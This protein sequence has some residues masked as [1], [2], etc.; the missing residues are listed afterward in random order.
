VERSE[1]FD[2]AVCCGSFDEA[3]AQLVEGGG[4]IGAQREV[5]KMTTLEHLR[6]G[7]SVVSAEHFGRVEPG[8]GTG[9]QDRVA[10]RGRRF[11]EDDVEP[12]TDV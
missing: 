11:C 4:R 8:V 3:V 6:D 10:E 12:N 1:I 9:S 5:V 7:R 2:G